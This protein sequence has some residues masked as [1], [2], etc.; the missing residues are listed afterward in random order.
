M[1]VD[2]GL[3]IITEKYL[4]PTIQLQQY[5]LAIAINLTENMSLECLH[6][7]KWQ[8]CFLGGRTSRGRCYLTTHRLLLELGVVVEVVSLLVNFYYYFGSC[9][10]QFFMG[11]KILH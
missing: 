9:K 11:G 2:G 3:V 1:V 8:Y 6:L 10:C 4:K 5:P 7:P